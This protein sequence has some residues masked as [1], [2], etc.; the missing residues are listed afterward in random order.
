MLRAFV[1]LTAALSQPCAALLVAGGPLLR[2]G[3]AP[4]VPRPLACAPPELPSKGLL[5]A[6]VR[7]GGRAT[8]SDIAAEAGIDV[9]ESQRQLLVLARLVGADVCVLA[10]ARPK[11]KVQSRRSVGWRATLSTPEARYKAISGL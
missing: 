3:T 6:I 1:V 11:T 7:C 2:A 10:V 9:D 4:R 8:A 5:R